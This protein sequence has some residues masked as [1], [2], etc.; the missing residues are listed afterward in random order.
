[1]CFLLVASQCLLMLVRA[2]LRALCQKEVNCRRG[3]GSSV[4]LLLLLQ[5]WCRHP[6]SM[7][8]LSLPPRTRACV[9]LGENTPG[10]NLP[11]SLRLLIL[12]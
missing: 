12:C 10:T 7:L 11:D 6:L 8:T 3:S 1:V 4:A 2:L 9:D 5:V